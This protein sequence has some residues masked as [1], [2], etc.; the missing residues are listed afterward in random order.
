MTGK[1]YK[2]HHDYHFGYGVEDTYNNDRLYLD[3][4]ECLVDELNNLND[5]NEQLKH[6]IKCLE[7]DKMELQQY[8][9]RI[10]GD[11]E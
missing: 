7:A 1:R 4:F 9:K 11:V 3:E 5:E 2:L 6:S 8:I 10:Q